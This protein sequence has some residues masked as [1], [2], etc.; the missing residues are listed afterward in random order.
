MDNLYL[1]ATQITYLKD[2]EKSISQVS[3]NSERTCF[4]LFLERPD[5]SLN[6]LLGINVPASQNALL[7]GEHLA[8]SFPEIQ[9]IALLPSGF[10][11]VRDNI[12]FSHRQAS[13]TDA[14]LFMVGYYFRRQQIKDKQ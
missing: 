8:E 11:E 13:M 5:K 9:R 12:L 10:V 7:F 6:Y 14:S 4:S 3:R 1:S 2:R